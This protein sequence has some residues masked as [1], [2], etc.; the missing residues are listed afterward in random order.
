MSKNILFVSPHMIGGGVEKALLG[1]LGKFDSKEYSVEAMFVRRRGAFSN[2]VPTYV[3]VSEIDLPDEQKETL[4]CG[5]T[6]SAVK[7]YMKKGRVFT[8]V[9]IACGKIIGNPFPEFLG[10]FKKLRVC[11]KK[12]D[13]AVCYHM[14]MPFIL[15]YVADKIVATKKIAWIHNDFLTTRFKVKQL[16]KYLEKYDQFY[17]VSQQLRDEFISIFPQYVNKTEVFHNIIDRDLILRQ[18]DNS[19]DWGDVSHGKRILSVGRLNKQKGFDLA[20]HVARM[21]KDSGYDFTWYIVGDGGERP[22]LEKQ[23]EEMELQDSVVLLGFKD[24]P[25][26]Y[27]KECDI[28]ALTSRHEGCCVVLDEVITLGK[29][30]VSTKVAGATEQIN[31]IKG[32]YAT[33]VDIDS[34]SIYNGIK[35]MLDRLPV[36]TN[37]E[38]SAFFED[39]FWKFEGFIK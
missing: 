38:V 26:P 21:L 15:A 33:L 22:V 25:Y 10:N 8:A 14:H 1:M 30:I 24:N 29:P 12:F 36:K 2:L 20:I 5:G 19:A 23:I 31:A 18:A 9:K 35:R 27:M 32:D 39:D 11:P 4:L 37:A 13:V 6:R 17:A 28:F 7:H 3:N 34:V 16:E